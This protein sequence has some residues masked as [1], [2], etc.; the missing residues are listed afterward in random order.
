ML[1]LDW[2]TC[3]GYPLRC[4]LRDKAACICASLCPHAGAWHYPKGLARS[5]YLQSA[6]LR[7]PRTSNAHKPHR[8]RPGN[9]PGA[10]PRCPTAHAQINVQERPSLH[11]RKHVLHKGGLACLP[12]LCERLEARFLP[13]ATSRCAIPSPPRKNVL[14]L[15][16]PQSRS[17]LPHQCGKQRRRF[18]CRRHMSGVALATFCDPIHPP[19]Q[20]RVV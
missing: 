19:V 11:T 8:P 14:A 13:S 10:K 5:P 12:G 7:Q 6:S 16:S 4:L 9:S 15:H 18:L 17:W 20:R 2:G 1:A 3:Y